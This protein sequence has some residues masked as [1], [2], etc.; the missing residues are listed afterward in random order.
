MLANSS[1]VSP[2]V[3]CFCRFFFGSRIFQAIFD[4]CWSGLPEGCCS[5]LGSLEWFWTVV[6]A[7]R[8]ARVG[9]GI[10]ERE[11]ADWNWKEFEEREFEDCWRELNDWRELLD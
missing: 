3:M 8:G 5:R 7:G 9:C 2:S 4:S 10:E 6:G 11:L 1:R